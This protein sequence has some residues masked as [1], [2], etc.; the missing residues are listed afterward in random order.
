M[1]MDHMKSMIRAA[2]I[3]GLA[4]LALSAVAS[5]N[6]SAFNLEWE[7]QGCQKVA[8]GT[9]QFKDGNCEEA[10]A[11]GG[12]AETGPLAKLAAGRKRSVDA[13][14]GSF[15]FNQG[16]AT[17]FQCTH[18]ASTDLITGG[19]P[20][21]GLAELKLTGCTTAKFNC[22]VTSKGATPGTIIATNLPTQLEKRTKAGVEVLADNFKQKTVG[23][24]KEIVTVEIKTSSG[25]EC[26]S[27]RSPVKIKGEVAAAV[28]GEELNF[29]ETAVEGNTLEEFG[30]AM[31]LSGKATQKG[32][33]GGKVKAS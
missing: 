16:K 19:K 20:G 24:T 17:E 22:T 7:V 23:T 1:E 6:A 31:T 12:F 9:G 14:G 30:F 10:L 13:A 29:P 26:E 3:A 18:F 27:Y 4:M 21:T 8:A 25:Q 15:V 28:E 32:L 11:G 5:A 2:L 33:G